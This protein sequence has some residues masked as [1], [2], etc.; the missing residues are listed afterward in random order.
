MGVPVISLYG[1]RHGTRF[2]MSLLSNA[3]LGD[4]AVS[5]KDMYKSLA[6]ELA[7]DTELLEALH[8]NLRR[9][10]EQSQLM[11]ERQYAREV[12]QAYRNILESVEL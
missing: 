1:R 4:L 11:N 6:V 7:N 5:T 10:M 12:E 3:G 8:E 9:N 2:G